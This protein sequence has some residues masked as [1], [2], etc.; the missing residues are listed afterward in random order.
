MPVAKIGE[1]SVLEAGS[2]VIND[3]SQTATI[4]LS[5][6]QYQF[7]AIA[8]ARPPNANFIVPDKN[9]GRFVFSGILPGFDYVF[10]FVTVGFLSDRY[11]DVDLSVRC[12][13]YDRVN[14]PVFRVDYVFIDQVPPELPVLSPPQSPPNP[15]LGGN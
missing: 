2:V 13:M 5:D 11:F 10:T 15:F 1:R 6:L 9:T 8:D 14:T 3:R 7:V 12:L 4:Q